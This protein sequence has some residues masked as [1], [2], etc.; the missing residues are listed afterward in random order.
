[1]LQRDV[2]S[3]SPPWGQLNPLQPKLRLQGFNPR[4]RMD[5]KGFIDELSASIE[6]EES[7]IPEIS[8]VIVEETY[9]EE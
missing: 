7:D 4:W 8:Q 3:T 6:R 2:N 5:W 1:M 9:I